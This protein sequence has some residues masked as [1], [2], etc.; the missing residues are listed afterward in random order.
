[1]DELKA[2]AQLPNMTVELTRRAV[3]D[4]EQVVIQLTARPSF[5]AVDTLVGAS[6]QW[7]GPW[8][9]LN[10]FVRMWA[11]MIDQPGTPAAPAGRRKAVPRAPQL[12]LV[13]PPDEK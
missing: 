11:D 5:A 9:M 4:G 6:L 7:L 3:A 8:M 1:M 12:R 2:T 13:R 10:P